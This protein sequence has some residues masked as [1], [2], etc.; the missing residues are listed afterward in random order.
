MSNEEMVQLGN[1]LKETREYLNL[2]QEFVSKTT[3]I[4]RTAVSAIEC[5]KRKVSSIELS[6]LAK[7]YNYP[8]SYFLEE[9]DTFKDR[10][11]HNLYRAA[12]DLTESDKQE[13]I[14]FAEFLRYSGKQSPATREKGNG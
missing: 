6:K 3:G 8:V 9:Q 1:R 14:R 5:G 7:L 2:S 11:L 12:G 13:L 4:P 10:T